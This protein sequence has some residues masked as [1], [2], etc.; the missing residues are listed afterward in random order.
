[1]KRLRARY[2][3]SQNDAY[4]IT[5][6]TQNREC[7]FGEIIDGE[8]ILND[9]GNIVGNIVNVGADLCVCPD[10]TDKTGGPGG[11]GEHIGSPLHL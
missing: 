5:I 10:K 2:D 1:V 11:P 3:Y 9:A 8:M 4:F 6:C 7:L